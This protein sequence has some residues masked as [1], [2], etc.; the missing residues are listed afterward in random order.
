MSIRP[1]SRGKLKEGIDKRKH[2]LDD[3]SRHMAAVVKEKKTIADTSRKLRFATREGAEEIKRALKNAAAQ[4][5]REFE[6][7]NKDLEKKHNDCKKAET[8]LAGRTKAAEKNALEAKKAVSRIKE[9]ASAREPVARAEKA[10]RGD[11]R[12]TK[13]HR[14]RQQRDRERSGRTR[15]KQKQQLINARLRW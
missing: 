15:D 12:F 4:T 1:E 14:S 2:A 10:S 11:A 3:R 7:Q 5:H 6:K 9:T 8:D 13:D